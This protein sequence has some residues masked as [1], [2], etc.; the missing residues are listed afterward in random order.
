MFGEYCV[1]FNFLS[2]ILKHVG[3]MSVYFSNNIPLTSNNIVYNKREG[4]AV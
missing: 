1:N 3:N 2:V 4:S